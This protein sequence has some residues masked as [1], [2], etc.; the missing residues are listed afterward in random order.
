MLSRIKDTLCVSPDHTFGILHK[1]DPYGAGDVIH[2]RKMGNLLRGKESQRAAVAAMRQ[3]LK[4]LNYH[5][6]DNMLEA[7]RFYDQV[8]F[9]LT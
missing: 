1:P 7:F 4:K 6:F 9:W 3:Q 2:N 8:I 5:H